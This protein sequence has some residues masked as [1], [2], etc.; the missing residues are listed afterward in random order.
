MR[1]ISSSAPASWLTT[2][3]MLRARARPTR[4]RFRHVLQN[5]QSSAPA[6]L[7]SRMLPA[8]A[9]LRAAPASRTIR[10]PGQPTLRM[11]SDR[12]Q[13]SF[14]DAAIPVIFEARPAHVSCEERHALRRFDSRQPNEC[15]TPASSVQSSDATRILQTCFARAIEHYELPRALQFDVSVRAC[16]VFDPR[17][18]FLAGRFRNSRH[19][20][21][22][23]ADSTFARDLMSGSRSTLLF[24]RSS[25]L[26]NGRIEIYARCASPVL[27]F[28]CVELLPP[29]QAQACL[30][31]RPGPAQARPGPVARRHCQSLPRSSRPQV[32]SAAT[33]SPLF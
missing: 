21:C 23:T 3:Q 1:I 8:S 2:A 18:L 32:R 11:Q 7:P 31:R 19:S 15:Q 26:P 17:F 33:N 29:A 20:S 4:V 14:A 16:R 24:L 25:A 10:R 5:S 13:R 6:Q 22:C 28:Q 9:A 12:R 30:P 27:R